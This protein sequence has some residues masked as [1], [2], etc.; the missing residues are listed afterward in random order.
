M[1]S[2]FETRLIV[3]E[4]DDGDLYGRSN[5]NCPCLPSYLFS[6]ELNA[7]ISC[8]SHNTKKQ[9]LL[10]TTIPLRFQSY[11]YLLA[12]IVKFNSSENLKCWCKLARHSVGDKGF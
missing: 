3:L 10:H 12:P 5:I 9:T 4:F 8:V 11:K 7:Y 6:H 1:K 2:V